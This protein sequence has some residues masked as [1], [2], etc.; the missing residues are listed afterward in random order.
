MVLLFYGF[1]V[2][3]G[4][5]LLL[6]GTDMYVCMFVCLCLYVSKR[7][8]IS[9]LVMGDDSDIEEYDRRNPEMSNAPHCMK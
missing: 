1:D 2:L 6:F 8:D 9:I 3:F 7:V 4:F 5:G